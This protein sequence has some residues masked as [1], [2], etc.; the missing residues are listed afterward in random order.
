LKRIQVGQVSY[1]FWFFSMDGH[2][3]I[4]W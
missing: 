2:M 1:S 3:D 4:Q